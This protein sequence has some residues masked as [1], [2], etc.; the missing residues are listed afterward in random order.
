M[1]LLVVTV[2]LAGRRGSRREV[3]GLKARC[4]FSFCVEEDLFPLNK[5]MYALRTQ[6]SPI[7]APAVSSPP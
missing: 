5:Q 7:K 2:S 1:G 6:D 3:A 4:Y